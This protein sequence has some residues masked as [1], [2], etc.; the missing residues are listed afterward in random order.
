MSYFAA[1]NQVEKISPKKKNKKKCQKS[2]LIA[3]SSRF[4]H[5]EWKK[6]IIKPVRYVWNEFNWNGILPSLGICRRTQN[7]C[8]RKMICWKLFLYS[9]FLVCHRRIHM[10]FFFLQF[11]MQLNSRFF[12]TVYPDIAQ[13]A[14]KLCNDWQ[15]LRCAQGNS[16]FQ[17]HSTHWCSARRCIDFF[18]IVKIIEFAKWSKCFSFNLSLFF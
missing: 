8:Q 6:E 17:F 14:I 7:D 2:M 5:N 13:I 16:M 9:F 1:S 12:S 11:A 4:N 3:K 15:A 10:F 18:L